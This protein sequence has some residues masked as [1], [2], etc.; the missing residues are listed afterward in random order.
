MFCNLS[1]ASTK[2]NQ[3]QIISTETLRELLP[4]NLRRVGPD[5]TLAD[6]RVGGVTKPLDSNGNLIILL[7][8]AASID[9]FVRCQ[10]QHNHMQ[11]DALNCCVNTTTPTSGR[12]DPV[13]G[14]NLIY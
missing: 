14:V 4:V 11:T 7:N 13:G 10:L 9:P 3:I 1:A 12:F 5:I 8:P 6:P 2:I